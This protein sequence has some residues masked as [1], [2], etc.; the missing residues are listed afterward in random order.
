MRRENSRR[1]SCRGLRRDD[2]RRGQRMQ[3][4]GGMNI[5]WNQIYH[6]A[7]MI[8]HVCSLVIS[9]LSM[10]LGRKFVTKEELQAVKA[11]VEERSARLERHHERLLKLEG[12]ITHLPTEKGFTNLA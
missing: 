7:A 8:A 4:G 11:T 2:L 12:I 3:H 5:D 6:A 9:W 10:R 1:N